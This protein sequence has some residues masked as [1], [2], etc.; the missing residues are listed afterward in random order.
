VFVSHDEAAVKRLCDRAILLEHGHMRMDGPAKEV[1]EAYHA[2]VYGQQVR[3]LVM[4]RQETE[5][6]AATPRLGPAAHPNPIEV[7]RFDPGAGFGDGS[8][9]IRTVEL[10]DGEGGA[11][12][13]WVQGGEPVTLRIEVD[14]H[15]PLA[16]P[17]VGFHFKDRLGQVLFGDNTWSTYRD[18]PT[19]VAAGDGLV[20]EFDFR[21][22]ILPA[23]RYSL[24]VAVADGTTQEHRQA[25][26]VHD[27]F[28]V[29]SHSSSVSTG[30]VGI[31]F[32]G[33]RLQRAQGDG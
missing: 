21:M 17:I 12:L 31:P 23:G 6:K 26:W 27:A 3:P 14:V 32:A 28:V 20:A 16:S 2:S 19:P 15:A 25:Q 5:R 11:P 1:C 10:L 9:A 7:F 13:A 33:I 18:A 4:D 22:P 30:L 24:D 29:E 8:A